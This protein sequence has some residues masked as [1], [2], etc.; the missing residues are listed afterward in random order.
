MQ[1]P[2]QFLRR[3]P[4]FL[5]LL[6]L[7]GVGIVVALSRRAV[8][9]EIE[10]VRAQRRT[11]AFEVT[12]TG[13]VEAQET[14]DLGFERGGKVTAVPVSVGDQVTRGKL[15]VKLDA[16]LASLDVALAE[17]NLASARVA[18]TLTVQ[19]AEERLRDATAKNRARLERLR[20]E[21]RDRKDER[22]HTEALRQKEIAEGGDDTVKSQTA[23]LNVRRAESAYRAAQ[24]TLSEA[25]VDAESSGRDAKHSLDT[26]QADL[27]KVIQAALGV[28]G[29]SA[30]E[31]A[32]EKARVLLADTALRTPLSGTVTAVEADV[33]EIVPSGT[34][35]ITVQSLGPHEVVADVPESDVVKLEKGQAADVSLDAYGEK[36]R[37][38]ATVADIGPAAKLVEGVPTFRV[39]FEL[40]TDDA[41]VK[42]G[43]TATITVRAAERR[44]A[45]V[46]PQRV[47][48]HRDDKT[49][50]RVLRE[51]RQTEEREVTTGLTGSDGMVEIIEGLTEGE[52]VVV[53][54]P[55]N[56]Q[57]RR[58]LF[59]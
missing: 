26:A 20:Q 34:P 33:G 19:Q 15:L 7:V 48:V 50:V 24:K 42:P 28:P 55:V 4:W 27:A 16:R 25:L 54:A 23:L 30:L 59:R 2:L 31:A 18:A 57:M 49:F 39:T 58:G 36:V 29:R 12:A 13:R 14:V 21:V 46:L 35:V 56:R 52:Q 9:E 5:L 38:P 44:D 8:P 41:R 40:S 47:F 43:M 45:L 51:S 32:A 11:V 17:A 53:R 1:N 6:V 22:D 37:F 3:R 10:T